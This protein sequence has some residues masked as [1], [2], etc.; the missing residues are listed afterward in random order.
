[1]WQITI[2]RVNNGYILTIPP[3]DNE[4]IEQETVL[5]E[6]KNDE[7]KAHENLLWEIMEHFNFGG[8]KHDKE[9]I[10]IIREKS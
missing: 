9:R 6:D 4:H 1:M 5:E 7:L 2:K 10:R 8:T 3:E